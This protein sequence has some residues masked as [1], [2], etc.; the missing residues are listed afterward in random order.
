[1][2]VNHGVMNDVTIDQTA[3]H[4]GAATLLILD[5]V[6]VQSVIHV[7]AVVLETS[8]LALIKMISGRCG[9]GSRSGGDGG[10]TSNALPRDFLD[11]ISIGRRSQRDHRAVMK[12]VIRMRMMRM[13]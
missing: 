7:G 5:E 10:F 6:N 9:R 12:A 8:I 4:V 1:M 2:R 13:L 3:V 11:L